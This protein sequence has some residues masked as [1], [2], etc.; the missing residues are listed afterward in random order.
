MGAQR[1]QRTS[2]SRQV[3]RPAL[4]SAPRNLSWSI[5]SIIGAVLILSID[6]QGQTLTY[7]GVPKVTITGISGALVSVE[8]AGEVVTVTWSEPIALGG[9]VVWPQADEA[10]RTRGGGYVQGFNLPL[11]ALPAVVSWTGMRTSGTTIRVAA[12]FNE[13]ALAVNSPSELRTVPSGF[14]ADSWVVAGSVL[15][16]TYLDD[17]SAETQMDWPN[18]TDEAIWVSGRRPANGLAPLT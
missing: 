8:V 2:R 1:Q 16:L 7:A 17:V 11:A 4:P 18:A 13:G 9:V 14:F 10:V 5:T 12:D 15:D 6:A 3:I